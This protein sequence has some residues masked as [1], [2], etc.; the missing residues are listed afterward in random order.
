M[1]D[2]L[3]AQSSDYDP[4]SIYFL[5]NQAY[6]KDIASAILSEVNLYKLTW[7]G[8]LNEYTENSELTFYG[9]ILR[10]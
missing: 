1:I 8:V 6:D 4:H 5:L 2:E 9:W 3:P 10:N 7:K